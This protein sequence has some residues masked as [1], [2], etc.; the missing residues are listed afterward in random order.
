MSADFGYVNARVRGMSA[1]LLPEAWYTSALG[2][3]DF[4]AFIGM[5]G[6]TPYGPD[7][8]E[9]QAS[10]RGLTAVD[11]ALARN[12][13]RTTHSLLNFSDGAPHEGIAIV[14]RRFDLDDLKTVARAK[15]AGRGA[16]GTGEA[17]L[18]VG[19]LN[20]S[21]LERMMAAPDLP[22]AAQALGI[23][24]HP[25]ARAFTK[26]ARAYASDGEL[27]AFELA[28]DRAHFESLFATAEE[29]NV[30]RP[31]AQYLRR[32]VDAANLRTAL[33]LRGRS[34]DLDRFFLPHGREV[35]R[36]A[37]AQIAGGGDLSVLAGT[38][39]AAV[40]DAG[41]GSAVEREI[42]AVLDGTARKVALRDPLGFGVALRYLRRKEAETARVR[43][44]ARGAFY[45][46]PR[47]RLE[48]ELRDA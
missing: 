26:A 18:G 43:L 33:K 5:L 8:E 45:G 24:G 6:G 46:V 29:M 4:D 15:H 13:H 22:A 7:L 1:R 10:A 37:F 36:E 12:F 40:A 27:F 41:D 25:L 11:R 30:P 48:K 28:L 39:F 9:A 31:F 14:L 19:D 20:R 44:L 2:A 21:T 34:V 3:T 32:E 17:L 23:T 42:R 35:S 38:A 16:D 47:E